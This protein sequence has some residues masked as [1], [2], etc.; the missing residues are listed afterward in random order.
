MDII[1]GQF[2]QILMC[3]FK[4]NCTQKS[5][6]KTS[7][8]TLL[9]KYACSTLTDATVNATVDAQSFTASRSQGSLLLVAPQGLV[10]EN[11][12]NEVVIY[13][14]IV[15]WLLAVFTLEKDNP[16]AK[17]VKIDGKTDG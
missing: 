9:A 6:N 2:H 14:Q 11:P 3:R 16:S 4:K 10:G 13:G 1:S 15:N 17:S 7:A 12:G 5:D 8:L